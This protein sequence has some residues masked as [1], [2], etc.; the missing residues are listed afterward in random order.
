KY[1]PDFGSAYDK[2]AHITAVYPVGQRGVFALGSL[3]ELT[4]SHLAIKE[5]PVRNEEIARF[6]TKEF[7]V[8]N[9][10]A[11]I[12]GC[13]VIVGARAVL[14]MMAEDLKKHNFAPETIGS[15]AKKGTAVVIFDKDASQFV[16][17]KAKLARL[18]SPAQQQQAP[19]S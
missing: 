14:N 1:C 16:A 3:A 13:H 17:S 2:N 11:S 18:T 6:A 8:E 12:N 19:A 9:S 5:L 4:N 15:V 10:T 7:L